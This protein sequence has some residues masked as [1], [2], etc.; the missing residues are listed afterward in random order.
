V[1]GRA[2]ILDFNGV[3]V[4][5]EPLHFR[6]FQSTLAELGEAFDDAECLAT[7]LAD[8]GRPPIGA[9]AVAELVARKSEHYLAL[10]ADGVPLFPGIPAFVTAAA[11]RC[12]LAIASGARRTEIEHIL[13]Q[14]GL[15]QHFSALASADDVPNGKPHPGVYLEAARRLGVAPAR[16]VAV[17]T[18]RPAGELVEA[19]R[20][21]A[22]LQDVDPGA[23][24]RDLL[25]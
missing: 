12:P 4:D 18:S 14:V 7:A 22:S 16:C 6:A 24:L 21:V 13:Q 17:T 25:G 2:I 19:D 15:R 5:D 1:T 9:D 3:V 23:L 11:A 8:R 20:T 10:I